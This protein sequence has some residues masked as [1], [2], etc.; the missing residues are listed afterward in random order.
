[1]SI[2]DLITFIATCDRCGQAAAFDG[3]V[4]QWTDR[5]RAISDLC[6]PAMGWIADTQTQICPQCL[7]RAVCAS[8]GHEWQGWT[9]IPAVLEP[10]AGTRLMMRVCGRCRR[11]EV[12]EFDEFDAHGRP[13]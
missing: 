4:A 10:P 12:D 3:E 11:D 5:S 1:M 2:T 9:Q 7:A 13:A 6:G 8:R